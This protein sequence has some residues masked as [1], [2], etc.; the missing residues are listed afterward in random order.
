[1][2]AVRQGTSDIV[3]VAIK[4][5][6]ETVPVIFRRCDIPKYF[7][8][9]LSVGTLANMGKEGPPYVRQ[10]RHAVYERE[11]FLVWYRTYLEN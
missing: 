4:A 11:S 7:G 1:M 8:N 2:D 10:G 5:L 9:C 3:D 6:R